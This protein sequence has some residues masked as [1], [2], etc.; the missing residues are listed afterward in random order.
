MCSQMCSQDAAPIRSTL[1]TE[2]TSTSHGGLELL[3]EDLV[4]PTTVA[5]NLELMRHAEQLMKVCC[6]TLSSR[7]P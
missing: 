1:M 5:R 3:A 2:A 4:D 6:R 7:I